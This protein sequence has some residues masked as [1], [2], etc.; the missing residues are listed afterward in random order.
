MVESALA[1]VL[2]IILLPT[3]AGDGDGEGD[4]EGEGEG[5][6]DGDGDGIISHSGPSS[7]TL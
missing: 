7:Q 6:G 5:D 2:D 1:T 4:G 3:Y